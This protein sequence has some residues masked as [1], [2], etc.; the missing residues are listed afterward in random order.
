MHTYLSSILFSLFLNTRR[1]KYMGLLAILLACALLIA[2]CLIQ[3]HVFHSSIGP[4]ADEGPWPL[5]PH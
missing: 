1:N 3:F 2:C 5:L 4:L